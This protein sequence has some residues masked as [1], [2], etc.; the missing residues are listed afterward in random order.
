MQ[1]HQLQVCGS[2]FSYYKYMGTS[3]KHSKSMSG[4][5]NLHIETAEKL[6]Q[7]SRRPLEWRGLA[8]RVAAVA[9]I[10][11]AFWHLSGAA[12]HA[13]CFLE[14]EGGSQGGGKLQQWL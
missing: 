9:A 12:P 8:P 10:V 11:G 1:S 5:A 2:R 7:E 13:R 3:K 14:A 4:S 6:S